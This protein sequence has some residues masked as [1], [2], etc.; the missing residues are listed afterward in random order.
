M[1]IDMHSHLADRRIYP[2]YWIE[3]IKK[4]LEEKLANEISAPIPESLIDSYLSGYLN[5]FDGAKKI[6]MMDECGIDR[7][8]VLQADFSFRQSEAGGEPDNLD[9]VMDNITIHRRMLQ[10]YPQR[11]HVFAGVDPRTG[12]KGVDLFELCIKEY[13]FSGL[14]IYPPCGYEIDY[15]GLYAFYEICN[16]RGL[17]VLIHIGPS[18]ANMKTAFRYPESLLKVSG[19]FPDITFILG[20]AA[21]LFYQ[22]SYVLPLMR[23]NVYLEISGYRKITDKRLLKARMKHLMAECP[24]Q[25]VFGSDWPMFTTAKQ[26]IA[27]FEQSDFMTEYQKERFFYKNALLILKK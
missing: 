13:G 15:R 22:E 12:K 19:E 21:L 5:D 8:V 24:E 16:Q 23:K 3:N 20:H 17:P 26:D 6:R 18:W 2:D 10:K 11:F 14:K 1:I 7:A 9:A 4:E 27:F 25:V